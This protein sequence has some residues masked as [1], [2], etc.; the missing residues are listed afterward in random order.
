[1]KL[2]HVNEGTIEG[3]QEVLKRAKAELKIEGAGTDSLVVAGDL[4]TVMNVH[5]ACHAAR[6]E[7]DPS[8]QL[9]GIYAVS[10]PWHLLLNWLYMMFRQYSNRDR[11]TSLERMRQ[12]LGRGKTDLD[13]KQPQFEEGW[14]LLRCVWI[15]RLLAMLQK[16]L[17]ENDESSDTWNPSSQDLFRTMANLHTRHMSQQ[18]VATAR[19][20]GDSARVNT[21]L[22]LRDCV[23]GWEYSAA[24]QDGDIG[25]MAATEKFLAQSFYGAG[26][27]K[28]GSL[29]LDRIL[30][31]TVH[32]SIAKSLRAAQLVNTSGK[33]GSWQGADHYQEILNGRIKDYDVPHATDHVIVRLED[34]ISAFVG[35][36]QTLSQCV[37]L[38]LGIGLSERRKRKRKQQVDILLVARDTTAYG[39]T[40]C[41]PPTRTTSGEEKGE[42]STSKEKMSAMQQA[43]QVWDSVN[44]S[45]RDESKNADDLLELGYLKLIGG[46]LDAFRSKVRDIRT[47]DVDVF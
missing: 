24:V 6:W 42:G 47:R 14:R 13:M 25:R 27:T 5:A 7:Q 9:E 33:A 34:K 18:A 17:Q 12:A 43:R 4:L 40:T 10:G 2:L 31:D 15:G 3:T 35:A 23:M 44:R 1:M 36:G 21:V 28:Y 22:F 32:P 38:C 11:S 16:E 41:R 19:A 29:L 39:I 8:G 30:E 37:T 46:A 20:A 26:Q 45:H